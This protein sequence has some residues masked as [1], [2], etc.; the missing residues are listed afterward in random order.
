MECQINL[1]HFEFH[2]EKE[3]KRQVYS[4]A[5]GN[6]ASMLIL[7]LR[8]GIFFPPH[9]LQHCSHI[10]HKLVNESLSPSMLDDEPKTA[11]SLFLR[12]L[13]LVKVLQ[14][15]EIERERA[16]DVHKMKLA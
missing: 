15:R 11:S 12:S 3:R 5:Q 1:N 16:S 10:R 13:L 2:R 7:S 9:T 14:E 8:Y 4:T 6:N